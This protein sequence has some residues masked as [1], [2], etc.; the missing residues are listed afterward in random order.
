MKLSSTRFLCCLLFACSLLELS[1][2][3]WNRQNQSSLTGRITGTVI[4]TMTYQP[5][6]FAT[7]ALRLQDSIK[8]MDGTISSAKGQ[9]KLTE[10]KLGAYDV[11]ISFIGYQSKTVRGIKLT[12]RKP[13]YDLGEVYLVQDEVLLDQ[14]EVTAEAAVIENKVDRIVYNADKDVSTV[15][16]DAADVLRKVPMLSV[17]LDGNVSLR[18]STQIRILLNGKPSGMFSNNV[19][20]ALKMFPA[21]QIKSVEVIT[22][23][24]AKYDAE[25]TG[26]IIN[27]ITKK[28]SVEGYSGT[29][30]GAIGTRQNRASLSVN[31]AKGRFGLNGSGNI[32]YSW[33]QEASNSFYREDRINGQNRVLEQVGVT[34]NSRIGF[35]GSAGAFYD[36]NAYNSINASANLRGHTFDRDGFQDAFFHD[37]TIDLIQNYRRSNINETLRSGYDINL[38]YRKTSKKPTEEFSVAFQLT[39][40]DSDDRYTYLQSSEEVALRL[41]EQAMNDGRNLESTIQVDYVYPLQKGLKMEVGAKGVFRDIDSD[42]HYDLFDLDAGRYERD[43]IRSD[44]FDYRQNVYAGYLSFTVEFNDKYSLVAGGRYERTDIEGDFSSAILPLPTTMTT[45]YPASS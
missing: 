30:T 12:P 40:N 23:P 31:A 35:W 32:Y 6:D 1:A 7:I 19:A 25:G 44:R 41:D 13:D 11:V 45:W 36:F 34:E 33:P 5:V 38:D 42:Y 4:D 29:F 26:G 27:I 18:G 39:G 3:N 14:V 8:D 16:G 21:D 24:G 15:G 22:T 17:D 37:P 43:P 2:Q 28:K 9:F 20:D 10:L